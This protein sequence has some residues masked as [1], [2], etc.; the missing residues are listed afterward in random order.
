MKIKISKKVLGI[1]SSKTSEIF[2]RTNALISQGENIINLSAGEPDFPL[3]NIEEVKN[4]LDQYEVNKYPP[5]LGLKKLQELI[6]LKYANFD[7]N[8]VFVSA[9]GAKQAIY[10]T[11]VSLIDPGDSVLIIK[12]SWVSYEEMIKLASGKTVCS[13]SLPNGRPD[14]E[15]ISQ[16]VEQEKVKVIILNNPVNPTGVVY[17]KDELLKIGQI[18]LENDCY[19]ISDEVYDSIVYEENKF[20]SMNF[21]FSENNFIIV[22]ST[23]KTY[24][25]MGFR[26]GYVLAC[27]EIIN[28][29]SKVQ[30]QISGGANLFG[31]ILACFMLENDES[32]VKKRKDEYE[33]RKKIVINFFARKKIEFIRPEGAFYLF[34]KVPENEESIE[35]CKR[36]L[37]DAKVALVPGDDFGRSGWV[38]LSFSVGLEKIKEGL[39]FLEKNL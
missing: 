24:V 36:I 17:T 3:N 16:K 32:E 33:Q 1:E 29:L 15:D 39:N 7:S 22:N 38:R 10:T 31:Q 6:A 18:A 28:V 13:E 11:L 23:S 5:V 30:S 12:P 37:N 34:F 35:F 27:V 19:V 9:G 14:V 20:Y 8:N 25:M 4:I 26:I 21:L 2:D